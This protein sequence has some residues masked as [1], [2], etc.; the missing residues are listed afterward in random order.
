MPNKLALGLIVSVLACLH[1]E[2]QTGS[3]TYSRKNV[4]DILGFEVRGSGDLPAGWS[5]GPAGTVIVESDIVHSGHCA[6]AT[7]SDP[8]SLG[9][10]QCH[11]QRY[12]RGLYWRAG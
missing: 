6:G 5:G 10:V 3:A 4:A 12:S 8:K 11:Q 9:T 2:S 7:R 1:A